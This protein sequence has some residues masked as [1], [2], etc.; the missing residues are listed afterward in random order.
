MRHILLVT[1]FAAAC[2]PLG[3]IYLKEDS[4]SP[5]TSP[6]GDADTDADTD[7]DTDTD[8]DGDTDADTDA[9]T[10]TDTDTQPD[11]F[12]PDYIVVQAYLGVSGNEIVD[13]AYDG[14]DASSYI[15]V[16][17]AQEAYF[18]TYDEALAC[19]LYYLPDATSASTQQLAWQVDWSPYWASD[20]CYRL[21]PDFY[22]TS[23]LYDIGV[24]SGSL[25]VEAMNDYTR[26]LL[27]EAYGE[28]Y[29]GDNGLG[30]ELHLGD[31]DDV[32]ESYWDY[33]PEDLQLYQGWA[34][35]ADRSMSTDFST[36]V[37]PEDMG[38]TNVVIYL[39]SFYYEAPDAWL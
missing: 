13:W 33:Y 23:P 20:T 26:D 31:L 25:L 35:Q 16:M 17:L 5:D 39:S 21:D 7:T 30:A 36:E 38:G 9:D 10:D 32:I 24:D 18:D 6:D 28:D 8:A 37:S 3:G 27:T 19:W 11:Y 12:H 4:G 2:M 14:H 29:Y 15:Y 34:F 1:L 22:G